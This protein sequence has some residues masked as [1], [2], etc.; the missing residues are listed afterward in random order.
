MTYITEDIKQAFNDFLA[1]QDFKQDN[2][3]QPSRLWKALV[4]N[5]L[6]PRKTFLKSY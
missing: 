5:I 1:E 6:T 2:V 4:L 3:T